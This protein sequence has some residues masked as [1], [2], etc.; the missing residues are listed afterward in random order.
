MAYVGGKAVGARHILDV[1]NHPMFDDMDYLEPFVG[2]GHVLRRVARK[3]S[4]EAS[5]DNPLLVCLL[6]GL[7]S[8]RKLPSIT[9]GRYARLRARRNVDFPSAVAAFAYSYNGK[10]WGG[11]ASVHSGRDQYRDYGEER[12]QYYRTL[13]HNPVF[14]QTT[15]RCRDYATLRPRHKLIYCD[16][17]Y[18]NTTQYGKPFDSARFWDVMRAWAQHNIVLVS[19][20]RAPSDFVCVAEAPKRMSLSRQVQAS[21]RMERLFVHARHAHMFTPRGTRSGDPRRARCGAKS[22]DRSH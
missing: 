4:Y 21:S 14:Q 12:K 9:A 6:R 15:V 11:Y 7:Q 17:P 13:M 1:L 8:G 10:E 16:P 20:Y 3:R 18:A 22:P 2:Y 19:E 5:D